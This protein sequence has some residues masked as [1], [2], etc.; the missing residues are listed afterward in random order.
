MASLLNVGILEVEF[1]DS[2]F[3][4]CQFST[5]FDVLHW[6]FARDGIPQQFMVRLWVSRAGSLLAMNTPG[7]LTH[8]YIRRCSIVFGNC[9]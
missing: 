2:K 5:E 1:P 3:K 7:R 4:W 9:G 6:E 8:F